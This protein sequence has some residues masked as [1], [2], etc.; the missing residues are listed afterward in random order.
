MLG[1]AVLPAMADY[2]NPL[3]G[4]EYATGDIAPQGRNDWENP[5]RVALNK[6]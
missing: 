2:E 1:C 4:F 6:Q 5:E 3:K